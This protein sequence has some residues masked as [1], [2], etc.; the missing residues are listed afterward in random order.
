MPRQ[1]NIFK[2][3]KVELDRSY[4][5]YTLEVKS[6]YFVMHPRGIKFK[7]I[8]TIVFFLVLCMIFVSFLYLISS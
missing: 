4:A 2:S 1:G 7:V 6:F 3:E 8:W 5:E